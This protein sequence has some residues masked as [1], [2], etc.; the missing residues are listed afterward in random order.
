MIHS[1]AAAA[2]ATALELV[3]TTNVNAQ[4]EAAAQR[5]KEGLN[6][7]LSRMEI[8]GC[9]NGVAALVHI[10]LG[11]AHDCDGGICKL[12]HE[13]IRAAMPG[14]RVG[15]LKRSLINA[16]VDALGGRTYVLSATHR[17]QDLDFTIGAFEEALAAMR[18]EGFV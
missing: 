13:Q 3:A 15:A 17:E 12:P 9:A 11:V 18:K 7:L 6:D 8:P 2:G 10:T 4:A 16:G 5:L 14:P 1:T